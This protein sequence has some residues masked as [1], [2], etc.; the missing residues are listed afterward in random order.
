MKFS[1]IILVVAIC[2]LARADI[3][4]SWTD[5]TNHLKGSTT[6]I[7]AGTKAPLNYSTSYPTLGTN[8]LFP[9]SALPVGLSYFAC[10]QI[11][12]NKDGS[13]CATPMSGEIQVQVNPA[14]EVD[15]QTMASTNL[16]SGWTVVSQ[17][18]LVFPTA[19]AQ[20][21]FFRTQ[22]RMIRT[23]LIVLPPSP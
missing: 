19:D 13:V 15:V 14:V 5:C 3:V 21:Q 1:A 12:T 8:F 23:N 22:Q 7:W 16:G 18:S 10:Q 4:F 9:A 11:A 20:Q 17:Q 2:S 6:L